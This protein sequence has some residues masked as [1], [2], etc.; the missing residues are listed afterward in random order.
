MTSLYRRSLL[1]SLAALSLTLPAKAAA[2]WTPEQSR[3]YEQHFLQPK[4][5][6][7]FPEYLQ[8]ITVKYASAMS[9]TV[10]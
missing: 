9:T 2:D 10:I 1:L 4:N 6:L 5:P 3:K 7:G 8:T